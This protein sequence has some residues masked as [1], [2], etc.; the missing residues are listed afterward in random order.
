MRKACFRPE[1][2]EQVSIRIELPKN[3]QVLTVADRYNHLYWTICVSSRF[4]SAVPIYSYLYT[5]SDGCLLR[6][7]GLTLTNGVHLERTRY[8]R[9]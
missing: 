7:A 2:T 6:I 4:R 1:R 5:E 9:Y 8:S 3:Y